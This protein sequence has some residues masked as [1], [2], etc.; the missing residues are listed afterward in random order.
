MQRHFQKSFTSYSG[1]KKIKL[2]ELYLDNLPI[3]NVKITFLKTSHIELGLERASVEINSNEIRTVVRVKSEEYI[4][5]TDVRFEDGYLHVTFPDNAKDFPVFILTIGG[6]VS[7]KKIEPALNPTK[8]TKQMNEFNIH[9][10]SR[11]GSQKFRPKDL[12]GAPVSNKT[13]TLMSVVVNKDGFSETYVASGH[14]RHKGIVAQISFR[15]GF[16]TLP[17]KLKVFIVDDVLEVSYNDGYGMLP[18]FDFTI[19][20]YVVDKE[21]TSVEKVLKVKDEL[22]DQQLN[23]ISYETQVTECGNSIDG[24]IVAKTKYTHLL[25]YVQIVGTEHER[26]LHFKQKRG[27]LIERVKE[28]LRW[29]LTQNMLAQRQVFVGTDEEFEATFSNIYEL[30]DKV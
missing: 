16:L 10:N 11:T 27:R 29:N 22:I 5:S 18:P 23:S 28:D 24:S 12:I 14:R 30:V 26:S 20:G 13:I 25:E 8:S 7:Y 19:S 9:L 15:R 2:T 17:V 4:L 21:N 1:N 6:E 3:E